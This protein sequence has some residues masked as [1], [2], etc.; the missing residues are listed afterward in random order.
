MRITSANNGEIVTTVKV[1]KH[2]EKNLS[3]LISQGEFRFTTVGAKGKSRISFSL[4][5]YGSENV[6][7]NSHHSLKT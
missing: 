5:Q 3:L 2:Q 4:F 7:H 6:L 1:F